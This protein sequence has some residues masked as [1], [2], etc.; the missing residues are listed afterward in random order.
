MVTWSAKGNNH[1]G[2]GVQHVDYD[3]MLLDTFQSGDPKRRLGGLRRAKIAEESSE[4]EDDDDPIYCAAPFNQP[5]VEAMAADPSIEPPQEGT[6]IYPKEVRGIL[7][8][9]APCRIASGDLAV[10]LEAK[11]RQSAQELQSF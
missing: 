7:W 6:P 8:P 11:R 3:N 1:P 4:D 2:V 9:C 10:G 5:D